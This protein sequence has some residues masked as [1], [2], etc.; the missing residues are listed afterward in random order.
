M[1]EPSLPK[2][3]KMDSYSD[4]LEAPVKSDVLAETAYQRIQ[5]AIRS[6]QIKPGQR[7]TETQLAKWISVSRTPVRAAILRLEAEG[8][9]MHSPR[10]GLILRQ[11]EY[12]EIVEL[13][14]MREILESNAAAL[15][16]RQ[17]TEPEIDFLQDII[18]VE[19]S[20]SPNDVIAVAHHNRMFHDALSQAAHNKFLLASISGLNNSMAL[21]GPTTLTQEGRWE[22]ALE[23]HRKIMQ[24]V[25]DRDAE[26]AR[27]TMTHH[28]RT[29]QRYRLKMKIGNKEKE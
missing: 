8:L 6:G 11:L 20:L 19:S 14:A 26:A 1:N 17:A 2:D 21:L 4:E 23:E 24:A 29:A 10:Q 5:D 3:K 25:R 18:E 12:Q 13:Y 28:I 22:E 7:V 27:V 9:L 16:A 15:A